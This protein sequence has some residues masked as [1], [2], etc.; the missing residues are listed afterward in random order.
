MGS[1]KKPKGGIANDNSIGSLV[2]CPLD[3][4]SKGFADIRI[5][6]NASHQIAFTYFCAPNVEV[7]YQDIKVIGWALIHSK[8]WWP[9]KSRLVRISG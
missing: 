9:D 7:R 3:A 4:S 5:T 2:F 1:L 8:D 6:I